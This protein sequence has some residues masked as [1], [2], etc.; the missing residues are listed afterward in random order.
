MSFQIE[1]NQRLVTVHL[2]KRRNIKHVYLRVLNPNLIQIKTNIYYT[3]LDARELIEK[4]MTWIENTIIRLEEKN[5]NDD[6]FLYLGE[7]KKIE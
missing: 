7:R 2:E 1:I 4:K 6:E 3:L 5:I